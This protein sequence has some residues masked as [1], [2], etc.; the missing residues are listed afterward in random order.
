MRLPWYSTFL[1]KVAKFWNIPINSKKALL[2]NHA[3]PT[4]ILRCVWRNFRIL[5]CL[6]M[7]KYKSK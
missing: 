4:K 1:D 6:I 5:K 2:K 7:N 3:P